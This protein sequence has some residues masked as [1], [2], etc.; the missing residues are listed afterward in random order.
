MVD[1]DG[2]VQYVGCDILIIV[3]VCC[4]KWVSVQICYSVKQQWVGVW[5]KNLEYC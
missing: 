5:V 3:V 2:E 4:G 1:V